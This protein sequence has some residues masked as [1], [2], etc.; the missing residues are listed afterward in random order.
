VVA[1]ALGGPLQAQEEERSSGLPFTSRIEWT[2]NFDA[3][4]GAFGF[5]NSLYTNPHPDPSGDLSDNWQEA[6]VK[7][8]LSASY[9]LGTSELYGK[10][11][12]VGERTFSVSPDLVGG[13]A[14]SYFIDEAF[15]GWRSGTALP[16]L[17]ENALDI[18]AGRVQYNLGTGFLLWDGAGEGGSRG[19]YWS[20]ARKAFE[21]GAVGRLNTGAHKLEIFYL[22]KDEV[23]ES[24]S[25]SWL[26]GA[27]YELSIAERVTLGATYMGWGADADVAPQRDEL[28]VYDFRV[29]ATPFASLPLSLEGEYAIEDH[30]DALDS[31]GWYVQASFAFEKVFWQ[32]T[33]YYRYAAFAGDDPD[34]GENE[35][36]DPLFLGFYDWG[37]WWQGEI[38]G[39]YFL[40]NS[41]LLSHE[42]RLH[43]TPIESIGTGLISF[44]FTADEPGSF[45]GEVTCATAD[46]LGFELD[47][48]MD[49]SLNDNFTASFIAA[50]ARPGDAIEQAYGRDED[51]S[52]GMF[53]LS[54]SY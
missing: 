32:P 31:N 42:V 13:D 15:I 33:L 8:A 46:D 17:G 48:Y 45:C 43:L 16:G 39:E 12:A 7:P 51:F 9:R 24:E 35:A 47:W 20:N 5:N 10:A 30:G 18:A 36:F 1:L 11:S 4:F 22:D 37:T 23:P 27:N 53:F 14:S 54:Y 41:N 34:T 2:F 52:Y 19:G 50:W 21:L 28:Q 38:A 40:S 6:F 25:E 3:A 26:W 49:W 29:Y 44:L